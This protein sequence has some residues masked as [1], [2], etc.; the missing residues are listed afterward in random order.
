MFGDVDQPAI[1]SPRCHFALIAVGSNALSDDATPRQRVERGLAALAAGPV[2][3]FR[4]SRLYR[5]P[6]F[7]PGSGPEFVNAACALETGESAEDLLARLHRIEA[8][9]GRERRTRWAPRVLDLDLLAWDDRIAPGPE[10]LRA[11]IDLPLE[12]QK[13]ETPERLILPHPRLQDRSFVLVPLADVAPDWVHP[14][15]GLRV[16]EMLAARPAAERADIRPLG[17]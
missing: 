4:I 16:R 5:A 6:A 14:L 10:A 15:L 9:A 12:R 17:D 1:L 11:W 13:T 2:R 3:D 7:P 8:E